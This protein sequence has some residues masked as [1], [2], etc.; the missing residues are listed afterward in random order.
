MALLCLLAWDA[1]GADLRVVQWFGTADGF[2]WRDHWLTAQVLHGGGRWLSGFAMIVV[3]VIAVR[4]FGFARRVSRPMRVWWLLTTLACLLLIP[5]IKSRSHISCP[6]DLAQFG[7][8]AHW[9][10]HADWRAWVAPGDGGPGRCFPSGH[11]SGAFSFLAGWFVLRGTAP[12]AARAWLATVIALG[13][14]FGVAQLA[15]GAHY[16]S[17]TLWTAWVCWTV[18]AAAWHAARRAGMKSP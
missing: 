4:P 12:L 10:S 14:V 16:P 8:S 7:G 17:H 13:V 11:A 2:A 1:S 3:V 18:S 6:W 9:L 15:R 5:Y